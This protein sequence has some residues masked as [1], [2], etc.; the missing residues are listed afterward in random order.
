ME[1]RVAKPLG[2]LGLPFGG[3]FVQLDVGL[4]TKWTKMVVV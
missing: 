4:L 1:R 2:G 3:G